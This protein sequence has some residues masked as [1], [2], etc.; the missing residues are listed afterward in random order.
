MYRKVP[1]AKIGMRVKCGDRYGYIFGQNYCAN[2]E[3]FFDDDGFGNCHPTWKMTYFDDEGNVIKNFGNDD[4][5]FK[6]GVPPSKYEVWTKD[7]PDDKSIMW[8][9]TLGKA[10]GEALRRMDA[11]WISY[12][13]MR[14]RQIPSE[15]VFDTL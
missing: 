11:D 8:A 4:V 7:F 5:T 10:K 13:D 1:F 6:T 9:T 14:G 15:S 3:I 12:I 2:F